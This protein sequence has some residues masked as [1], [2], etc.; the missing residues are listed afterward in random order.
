MWPNDSREL[1]VQEL[2]A[3]ASMLGLTREAFKRW[4]PTVREA[5]LSGAEVDASGAA[6]SDTTGAWS[7]LVEGLVAY[8]ASITYGHRVRQGVEAMGVSMSPSRSG[9]ARSGDLAD[10]AHRIVADALDMTPDGV[11][12][13]QAELDSIPTV[14]SLQQDHLATVSNRMVNTPD[15]VFADIAAEIDTSLAEGEDVANMSARV[16]KYLDSSTGDWQ[17]RA[18]T[19]A[20]TEAC[21]AQSSATRNAA[22]LAQQQDGMERDQCWVATMDAVTRDTH[23]AADG[24]R[25]PLGGKFTVGGYSLDGPGDPNGPV[26]EVARCRCALSILH[27]SDPLP[28]EMDR[29]TE[30]STGDS[31]VKRRGGRSKQDELERRREEGIVRARD[32]PDGIGDAGT[33]ASIGT[34]HDQSEESIMAGSSNVRRFADDDQDNTPPEQDEGDNG[35]DNAG[36]SEDRGGFTD[37]VVAVLDTVSEDGRRIAPDADISFRDFPLPLMWQQQSDDEHAGAYTVGKITDGAVQD[38]AVLASGSLLDTDEASKAADQISEGVSKPSIDLGGY[39]WQYTDPD[40]TPLSEDE[41][42]RAMSG[43][44][45]VQVVETITAG[46]VMGVTLVP[47]PA[48]GDTSIDLNGGPEEGGSEQQQVT[49]SGGTVVYP[50]GHFADPKLSGPTPLHITDDGRIVGHLALFGTC[51]TGM[52]GEC[53]TPPKSRTGYAHFHTAPPVALDDGSETPVGRLTVATGH[54]GSSDSGAAAMAHYENTGTCFALVRAGEDAHGIWVSG[55]PAPGVDDATL[56]QG[57]SAPL[58]GDWRNMG[59]GLELVAALAVNTPGFPVTASGAVGEDGRAA[60]LVASIAPRRH[61]RAPSA[62]DIADKVFDRIDRRD[63][64]AEARRLVAS[65]GKLDRRAEAKR[66]MSMIDG[67]R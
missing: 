4:L 50:A 7:K 12:N 66:I 31:T 27:P 42:D 64:R 61:Q 39:S 3:E 65:V 45:S 9:S 18:E 13:L 38:G 58:S 40:G 10:V 11:A 35:G 5:V 62:D 34:G 55:A 63:K 30:R 52:A 14:R 54:A 53:V 57:M 56:Q 16:Q 8:G 41:L 6:L 1:L 25:V 28:D 49:A 60:S 2:E 37:A 29:H 26:E 22:M 59:S 46:T 47:I 17:G 19:V 24:Q 15:E 33:V 43:D 51:H 21:G 20:R 32:D 44:E 48:F 23:W 36:Q 67:D